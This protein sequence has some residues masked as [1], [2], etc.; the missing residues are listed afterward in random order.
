MPFNPLTAPRRFV[1]ASGLAIMLAPFAAGAEEVVATVDGVEITES[2]VALAAEDL[3]D[4]LRQMP[5]EQHQQF[6]IS[7]LADLEILSRAAREADIEDDPDFVRRHDYVSKRTMMEEFLAREADAVATDEAMRELYDT[8]IPEMEPEPEVRAHH[9]LTESEAEAAD[10]VAAL[11]EGGDFEEL[12]REH[13][14]DPGSAEEGGDLGYFTRDQM[15]DPFAEVAFALEPGEVSDPVETQFGWHVI[16]V[17][18]QREGE[19]P[20]FEEVEDELRTMLVRQAQRDTVLELR[21]AAEIEIEAEEGEVDLE[22]APESDDPV[23]PE[24][25]E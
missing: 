16:R 20:S 8:V 18:D 19:H 12:A 7:Y 22:G 23:T 5:P 15:I 3:R 11:E 9:I 17:E 2:D 21:E 4:S 14:T 25:V 10:I 24:A 1:L 6:L 13:S